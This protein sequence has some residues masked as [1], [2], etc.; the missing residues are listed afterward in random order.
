MA[1]TVAYTITHKHKSYSEA[2]AIQVIEEAG[3]RSAPPCEHFGLCGGCSLQH[4][5]PEHQ[6][7]LKQET[8][9]NQ[10]QHF[11]KVTPKKLLPPLVA[12]TVG[13]RHKARLGVKY[14]IKKEKVLVGF[15]EKSSNYLAE[16]SRCVVLHPRVGE[17]FEALKE[18]IASLE[19]YKHIPQIEVAIGDTEVALVFRHLVSLTEQDKATLQAFGKQ[20]D[21][22]IYL[23]PNAPDVVCKL[24]PSDGIERLSY[25]LPDF[26]LTYL[27]HPLDFTQI[28]L[29]MNKRMVKQALELLDAKPNE[30]VLDLYCG[31]GNFSLPI[32]KTAKS[33]IGVEGSE[34]MV[35]RASTNAKLNHLENIRFY[36]SNLDAPDASQPWM[37][38]HFDKVLL[39]PPRVGAKAILPHL[40]KHNPTRI[41]YISCNPATLARDAG[42]LVALGYE[43][44]HAGIMDMFPHTAHIEAMAVFEKKGS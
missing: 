16:L 42:E 34:E 2:Q 32:A 1:E 27:F 43:L 9:L 40:A 14:V 24:W 28:N 20:Y 29:A 44:T 18:L 5:L 39:D 35:V 22:Q 4:M 3:E 41:V 38:M 21:F 31:I 12:E 25:T 10:L 6:R 17:A 8:L 7:N 19:A 37:G 11:G 26:G 30:T 13:Y 33:V 36:A 15:R 23:Q